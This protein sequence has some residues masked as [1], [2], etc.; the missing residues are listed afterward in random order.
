MAKEDA[1]QVEVPGTP[2]PSFDWRVLEHNVNEAVAAVRDCE[3]ALRAARAGEKA[4]RLRLADAR[5][6][7]GAPI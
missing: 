1:K 5:R 7:I 6:S 2:A 4:A 3:A